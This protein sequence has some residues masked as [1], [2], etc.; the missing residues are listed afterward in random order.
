MDRYPGCSSIDAPLGRWG[1]KS[2]HKWSHGKGD[3]GGEGS[4]ASFR[5]ATLL[6][7]GW[8]LTKLRV[9]QDGRA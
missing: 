9:L 4:S 8:W 7:G 6:V 1:E 2:S 3:L 5:G